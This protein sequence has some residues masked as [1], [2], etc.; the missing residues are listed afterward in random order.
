MSLCASQ[1]KG[2][3]VFSNRNVHPS[4]SCMINLS[5][6]P[7]GSRRPRFSFFFF[8]LS[9]N[10]PSYQWHKRQNHHPKS[11]T[12]IYLTGQAR[13]QNRCPIQETLNKTN[14]SHQRSGVIRS[15]NQPVNHQF[16]QKTNCFSMKHFLKT[17]RTEPAHFQEKH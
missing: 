9:K 7:Q 12:T 2:N 10:R 14:Q 15:A 6:N 1:R 3:L 13:Q 8:T 5:I 17:K 16:Q 11:T 4:K